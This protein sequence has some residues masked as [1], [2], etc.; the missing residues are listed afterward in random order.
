MRESLAELVFKEGIENPVI[1][2]GIATFDEARLQMTTTFA[3]PIGYH[4]EELS[5]P[6]D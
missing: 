4:V 5:E 1:T 2:S 3:Y 6:L